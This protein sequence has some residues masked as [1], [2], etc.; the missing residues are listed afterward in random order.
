MKLAK[1]DSGRP[2]MSIHKK[3][4]IS[5][6]SS[7]MLLIAIPAAATVSGWSNPVNV[8]TPGAN[9][10]EA[11]LVV[12]QAGMAIAIWEI[13]D[14]AL[15]FVQ[16]SSRPAGGAWSEPVTLSDAES[17]A[18][19]PQIT[20]DS[21]GLVTALWEKENENEN[22][23]IQSRTSLSGETWSPVEDISD[24]NLDAAFPEITVDSTGLV[25]AVWEGFDGQDKFI[26]STTRPRGGSWSEVENISPESQLSERVKIQADAAGMVT[27]IWIATDE[28]GNTIQSSYRPV[29]GVWSLPENVSAAPTDFTLRPQISVG[30]S[31]QAIAVWGI[32]DSG[33][34]VI[35]SSFRNSDGDWLGPTTLSASGQHAKRP[36][37]T[38]DP[39]GLATAIWLRADDNG[40]DDI[41]QSSTSLNGGAW[42]SPVNLTQPGFDAGVPQIIVDSSGQV[43]AIWR[44]EDVNGDD[45]LIQTS[46]RPRDGQ[47]STPVTLSVQGERSF[48]PQVAQ[49]LSGNLTALWTRNDVGNDDIVQSSFYNVPII[50]PI[51]SPTPVPALATT[52]SDLQWLYLWGPVASIAGICLLASSRQARGRSS[53]DIRG[54]LVDQTYL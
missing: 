28:T 11:K 19:D 30:S 17:N 50:T 34:D 29:S 12:D 32:R 10:V 7:L 27:A 13:E 4:S 6:A 49:D 41:V 48:D 38:V 21:T 35:K 20:V 16:S 36:Q 43:T 40:S 1:N 31:G 42:S 8:S 52:G 53:Q 18:Y 47:W 22:D 37:V 23:V 9:A 14:G 46:T 3:I 44:R 51:T 5:L 54:S 15:N 33:S 25:T 45:D 2:Q 24:A 26:Q 39:S